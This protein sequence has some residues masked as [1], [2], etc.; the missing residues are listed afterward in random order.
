MIE[1]VTLL[2]GFGSG[3]LWYGTVGT[4]AAALAAA[5]SSAGAEALGGVGAIG[6]IGAFGAACA[7]LG[8]TGAV[9]VKFPAART[10][11]R[12]RGAAKLLSRGDNVDRL[13]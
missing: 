13:R 9:A 6:I 1:Q 7:V 2:A 4:A 10:A 8:S 5:S 3:V 12:V 11:R